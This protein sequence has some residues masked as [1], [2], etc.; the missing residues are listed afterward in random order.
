MCHYI[1]PFNKVDD[2]NFK[3]KAMSTLRKP[4]FNSNKSINFKFYKY[5]RRAFNYGN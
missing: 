4:A 1:I 2:E 5:G 3:I